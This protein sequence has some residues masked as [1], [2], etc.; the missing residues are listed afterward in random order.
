[1]LMFEVYV[2]WYC[3]CCGDFEVV[4]V[5]S[6]VWVCVVVIDVVG[7]YCLCVWC[8]GVVFCG[9]VE[10]RMFGLLRWL[11]VFFWVCWFDEFVCEVDECVWRVLV[12]GDFC[13]DVVGVEMVWGD[14]I[15]RRGVFVCDWRGSV[16]DVGR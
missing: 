1:M 11:V 6:W 3:Y 8:D 2:W 14:D 13:E 12:G 10:W 4:F 5:L 7:W 15:C 16:V 9:Y